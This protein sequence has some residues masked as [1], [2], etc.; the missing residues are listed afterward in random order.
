MELETGSDIMKRILFATTILA[1]LSGAAIADDIKIGIVMGFTGPI[2]SLTPPMADS[3]EL[4][5]KEVNDSGLLLDG[6][7]KLVPVRADSTCVD[8][9]VATAAAERLVTSDNVAAI[10]GADCSGVTVAVVNGVSAPNGVP[11]ISPSATS[12]ALTT[13]EDRG[14]FFRTVPSDARQGEVLAEIVK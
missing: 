11:T 13:I 4:A 12:P 9:A 8:S 1:G 2:E 7:H 10:V 14:Y 3:V 5:L 6:E